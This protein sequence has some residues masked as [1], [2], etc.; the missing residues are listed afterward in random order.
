MQ[1]T[2]HLLTKTTTYKNKQ[3]ATQTA[4][5]TFK[6]AKHPQVFS[7]PFSIGWSC[8]IAILQR[9]FEAPAAGAGTWTWEGLAP[10]PLCY[11]EDG[12]EIQ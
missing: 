6:A 12:A 8:V 5:Q 2:L 9:S 4:L 7:V 10:N 11:W 3:Q 1:K